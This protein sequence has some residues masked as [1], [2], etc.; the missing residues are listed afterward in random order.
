MELSFA[1]FM[2][3]FRLVCDTSS[4]GWQ[5]FSYLIGGYLDSRA[6]RGILGAH[7]LGHRWGGRVGI[8][9]AGGSFVRRESRPFRCRPFDAAESGESWIHPERARPPVI[10]NVALGIF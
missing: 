1:I 10:F 7:R 3:Y 9:C 8:D 6:T 4:K 2:P 5:G